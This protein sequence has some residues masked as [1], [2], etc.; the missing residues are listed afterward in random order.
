MSSSTKKLYYRNQALKGGNLDIKKFKASRR[1][2]GYGIFSSL[3]KRF[4]IPL[5][6]LLGREAIKGGADIV[7]DIM[8]GINLAKNTLK[9][10]AASSL[11]NLG[12]KIEH[13][14]FGRKRRKR[15]STKKKSTSS[16]IIVK[17]KGRKTKKS[18]TKKKRK[19][20]KSTQ[21]D[22]FKTF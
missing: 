15:S 9:R 4:A 10:K 13:S 5:I 1:Q 8:P 11:R 2:R 12:E 7:S 3:A 6:K 20:S 22:I 19:N 18:K 17:G 16:T 14:G 21:R